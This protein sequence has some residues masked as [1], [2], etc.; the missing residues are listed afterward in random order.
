M[1]S[2]RE[3]RPPDG[4]DGA[5]GAAY[6]QG[7]TR[8]P[9]LV[10]IPIDAL[11]DLAADR[12]KL[13]SRSEYALLALVHLARHADKGFLSVQS[14]AAAQN[15]PARF[16]EQILLTLKRGRYV[17]SLKGQR[18][19]FCLARP[20]ER[21]TLAEIIRLFDGALAPTE[22]ASRYFYD[23]TPIEKERK[24]LRVLK[25]IRDMVSQ[26]LEATTLADVM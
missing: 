13:T 11:V 26:R 20:P 5:G 23:T 3:R 7:L 10:T 24:M 22:S 16:L 6:P 9:S 8:P 1:P 12:V 2:T 15:I 19:G 18:G 21:I 4:E 25:E 14:I 17:R